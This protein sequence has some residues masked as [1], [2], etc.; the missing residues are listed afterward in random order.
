MLLNE[1]Q[2]EMTDHE[3]KASILWEAFKQRLGHSN[4]H[5]MHFDLQDL[6]EHRADPQIFHD[7]EQPFTQEEIDEVVKNLPNDK[8]PGPDGFNNEFLKACWGIIKEDIIELILAFHA[9]TINL[10]SINTSYITLVPKKDVPLTPN[11]FRPISL[12]NGVLK[13]ITKLLANRLQKVILQLV[14]INQ[15][16]FLKDTMIQ[17]CVG[18]AYEYI[19]QSQIKRGNASD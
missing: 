7:L 10:E 16:D 8:S 5:T 6:Y 9:G 1:D 12:L 11:D 2:I 19:H 3:G 14:H 17:D 18:W 4:G 15:Y 13:I